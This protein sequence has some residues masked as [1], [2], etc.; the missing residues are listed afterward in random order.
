[1][2]KIRRL[3]VNKKT[4]RQSKCKQSSRS[5]AKDKHNLWRDK[6]LIEVTRSTYS[7]L[8]SSNLHVKEQSTRT[9]GKEEK[10]K[11]GKEIHEIFLSNDA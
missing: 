7:T 11:Y 6:A 1:M 3:A 4:T 2:T 5:K 8:S 10:E 9:A